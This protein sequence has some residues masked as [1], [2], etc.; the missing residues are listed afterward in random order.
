MTVRSRKSG[1]TGTIAG[2][3]TPASL[4]GTITGTSLTLMPPPGPGATFSGTVAGNRMTGILIGSG[5]GSQIA[6][7]AAT[8][9]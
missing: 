6:T 3:G 4:S 2:N 1:C 7:F 5:D 8:K 9:Q